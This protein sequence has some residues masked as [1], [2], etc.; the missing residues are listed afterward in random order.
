MTNAERI[1]ANNAELRKS[2]EMAETLPDVSVDGG[3]P[4]EGEYVIT[5]TKPDS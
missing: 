4:Y 3:D 1:Q 5:D 2:I